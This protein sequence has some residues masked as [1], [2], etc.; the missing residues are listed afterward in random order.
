MKKNMLEQ[1]H[2]F[3]R[4]KIFD[5]K[6]VEILGMKIEMLSNIEVFDK[7]EFFEIVSF[8]PS[9]QSSFK[10]GPSYEKSILAWSKTLFCGGWIL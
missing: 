5:E 3:S 8:A 7:I 6:T 9:C 4:E 10:K 2:R 1:I